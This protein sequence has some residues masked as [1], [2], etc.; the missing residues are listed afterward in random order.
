[1]TPVT[2]PAQGGRE[3]DAHDGPPLGH[4]ERVGGLAE[5]VRDDLQ[6]LLG[7]AHDDRDHQHRERDGAHDAE[8]DA[9]AEEEREEGVGEEA[10]HD[11]RD[12]GHDV[13]EEDER[14]LEPAV[15]VLAA[16]RSPP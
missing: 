15:S 10:G 11:R 8:A 4:A 7:G 3:H 2:M 9:R 13:H 6:H 12:A 16:G 5:P 1:M 14:L